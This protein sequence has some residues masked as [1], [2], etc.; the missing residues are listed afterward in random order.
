M[1]GGSLCAASAGNYWAL[2]VAV[3][4]QRATAQAH[5]ETVRQLMYSLSRRKTS[6]LYGSPWRISER[7]PWG[8][9]LAQG[10]RPDFAYERE[11]CQ[12]MIQP[13]SIHGSAGQLPEGAPMSLS[14]RSNMRILSG[15]RQRKSHRPRIQPGLRSALPNGPTRIS[16]G[17]VLAVATIFRKAQPEDA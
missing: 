6:L 17:E 5:R 2:A 11:P 10:M 13:D 9:P 3:E 8:K 16:R 14:I 4:R 12:Y 7:G 1:N 15:D